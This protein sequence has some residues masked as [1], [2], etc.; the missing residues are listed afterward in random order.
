MFESNLGKNLYWMLN[1]TS[2]TNKPLIYFLKYFKY[3]ILVTITENDMKIVLFENVQHDKYQIIF[4]GQSIILNVSN[5]ILFEVSELNVFS[6]QHKSFSN[7]SWFTQ[8]QLEHTSFNFWYYSW[9]ARSQNLDI[10]L[11]FLH[12]VVH[13]WASKIEGFQALLKMVS[14]NPSKKSPT[15]KCQIQHFFNF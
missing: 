14:C 9:F 1:L 11:P 8:I 3:S 10:L 12:I 6:A 5:E 2:R 4:I 13:L 7:W 15:L